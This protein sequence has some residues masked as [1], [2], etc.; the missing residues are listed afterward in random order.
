MF[1]FF[2]NPKE[3]ELSEVFIGDVRELRPALWSKQSCLCQHIDETKQDEQ[4][5]TDRSDFF[6]GLDR[7]DFSLVRTMQ[8]PHGNQGRVNHIFRSPHFEKLIYLSCS[9]HIYLADPSDYD[10]AFGD[11]STDNIDRSYREDASAF[12]AEGEGSSKPVGE[13][14]ED[15]EDSEMSLEE[16]LESADAE[17]DRRERSE[18]E[19]L[20]ETLAPHIEEMECI[21]G[22]PEEWKKGIVPEHENDE[23]LQV[24]V[25]MTSRKTLGMPGEDYQEDIDHYKYV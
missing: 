22:G 2:D 10:V 13:I 16:F 18:L 4:L 14:L 15:L 11:I 12:V 6:D 7:L 5:D 21:S 20:M 23:P 8:C 25:D 3:R 9:G 24:E 17:V 1:D 19:K